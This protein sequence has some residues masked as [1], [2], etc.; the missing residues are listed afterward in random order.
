MILSFIYDLI[1]RY[2]GEERPRDSL[3]D[4]VD[5]SPGFMV[6][7]GIRYVQVSHPNVKITI[8]A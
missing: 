5:F 6:D 8:D 7:C 4:P 1:G 3:G 2:F